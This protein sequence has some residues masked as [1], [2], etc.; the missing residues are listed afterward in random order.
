MPGSLLAILC[1]V[2]QSTGQSASESCAQGVGRRQLSADAGT[3]SNICTEIDH[4]QEDVSRG[5]IPQAASPPGPTFGAETG[6]ASMRGVP[7][8][9]PGPVERLVRGGG[10]KAEERQGTNMPVEEPG[11]LEGK[12]P[13]RVKPEAHVFYPG[14]QALDSI[15]GMQWMPD[16]MCPPRGGMFSWEQSRDSRRGQGRNQGVVD[17]V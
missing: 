13:G 15:L 17:S 3:I 14:C 8:S 11:V 12:G 5:H 4:S 16:C 6:R 9:S 10:G 1:A 2:F 7:S